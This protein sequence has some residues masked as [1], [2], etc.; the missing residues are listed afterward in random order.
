MFFKIFISGSRAGAI[1]AV[2]WATL[3]YF[4]EDGYV[5]STRKIISTARYIA[6]G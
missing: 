3:M 4:G 2:C 1:I 5:E 6:K